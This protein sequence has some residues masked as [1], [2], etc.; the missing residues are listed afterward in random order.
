MGI[1]GNIILKVF[2]IGLILIGPV[3]AQSGDDVTIDMSLSQ[4]VINLDGTAYLMITVNSTK[5][6][7]P[8]PQLPNLSMFDVY[9]QGTSTN[10]SIVN[11]A[12]QRS[13]T[14]NYQLRPRRVGTF[15]IKPAWIAYNH[16]H[17]ESKEITLQVIGSGQTPPAGTNQ[18]QQKQGTS[19]EVESSDDIFLTASLDKK[20]AYVNEQVTLSVKFYSAIQLYSQPDYTQPQTTDFWADMME[21]QKTYYQVVNGRRYRVIEINTA[22]FPT[23]AGD[24]SIGSAMV[25]ARVPVE[26]RRRRNDPF[27]VFDDF[28]G[29]GEEKTIRSKPLKMNVKPLPSEGKPDNYTGSVGNYKISASADKMSVEVNQ[30]VTV[31]YKISGTGNIKTI[32]EPAIRDLN[33][34]RV[35][36]ASSSEKVSKVGGVVGGTKVFEEVYIPK[37][38]GKLT[39]PGVF[40]NYFN[41]ATKKYQEISTN[42]IIINVKPAQEGEYA[43]IP[44]TPV[45]GRV[46]DTNAKDIRYIKTDPHGLA[47]S[48]SLILFHPLFLILNGIPVLLLVV[49]LVGQGRRRKLATDIGYARSRQ[50]KKKA[51]KRLAV[52]RKLTDSGQPDKFYFEIRQALFSYVAD[53]LNVSPH[54]LTSDR[55]LEIIAEAGA[56]ETI[57]KEMSDLLKRADFAQY[58]SANVDKKQIQES[59]HAAEKIM[60]ELE[61]IN[62]V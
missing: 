47:L 9:S 48:S 53:K 55:V 41:P 3:F 58:S 26:R 12:M 24:L 13:V 16:K 8:D 57:T 54:G 40:L 20:T 21:P 32:A 7:L 52:A 39:I 1:T 35:Y 6:D 10:I 62:F 60:V 49:V 59:L 37:R 27:S 23:R 51:R 34:F 31:T 2:L 11:G 50:A 38:A 29:A 61:G 56:G 33:D 28:F 14:Y 42:S 18:Q 36:R 46:I 25:T 4:E 19:S 45:A 44:I 43:D 30:P 17:Y 22:L 5:Q 15:V